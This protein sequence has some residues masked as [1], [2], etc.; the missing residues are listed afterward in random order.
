M[1]AEVVVTE[2]L[3]DV[4][5]TQIRLTLQ[6]ATGKEIL[7]EQLLDPEIIGGVVTQPTVGVDG[8]DVK[9]IDAQTGVDWLRLMIASLK[10]AVESSDG[11]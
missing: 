2:K 6:A 10:D 11:N 4:E 5:V 1:R 8:S 7:V 9:I 3:T